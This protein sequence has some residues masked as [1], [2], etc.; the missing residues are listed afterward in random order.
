MDEGSRRPAAG[1]STPAAGTP[2]GTSPEFRMAVILQG[3]GAQV[4]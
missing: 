2:M 1:G 4:A 3:R